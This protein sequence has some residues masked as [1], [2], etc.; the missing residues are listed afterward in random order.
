MKVQRTLL[1]PRFS[2]LR[3]GPARI[4]PLV[5][6]PGGHAQQTLVTGFCIEVDPAF[7]LGPCQSQDGQADERRGAKLAGGVEGPGGM[8]KKKHGP[9]QSEWGQPRKRTGRKIIAQ[10]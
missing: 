1:H 10:A 9:N 2:N 7:S 3:V 8:P 4:A 6:I 5:D